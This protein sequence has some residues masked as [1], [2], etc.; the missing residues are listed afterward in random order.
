MGSGRQGQPSASCPV[1]DTGQVLFFLLPPSP[2]GKPNRLV[3]GPVLKGW[4][5]KQTPRDTH[6]VNVGTQDVEMMEW[7]PEGLS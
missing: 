7:R 3:L 5:Q 2:L 1:P 6:R 4:G